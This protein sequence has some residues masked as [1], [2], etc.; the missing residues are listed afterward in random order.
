[1]GR[2]PGSS[3]TDYATVIASELSVVVQQTRLDSREA[4]PAP[5]T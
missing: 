3:D 4:E 5:L 1:M 2:I